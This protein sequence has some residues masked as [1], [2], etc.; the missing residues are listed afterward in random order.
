MLPHVPWVHEHDKTCMKKR[1][2]LKKVTF[3]PK[4]AISRKKVARK[5]LCGKNANQKAH[6]HVNCVLMVQNME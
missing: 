2:F 5:S 1:L 4:L 3:E 6:F